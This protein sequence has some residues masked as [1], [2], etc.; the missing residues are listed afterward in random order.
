MSATRTQ[1]YLSEEQ[2]RR[3]DA[4]AEA[5][6]VTLAEIVRRAL[7]AYFADVHADPSA[8][9]AATFGADPDARNPDRDEWAHA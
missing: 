6:G 2:R 5:E 3:I 4:L 1:V 7:N 8:A 9:L